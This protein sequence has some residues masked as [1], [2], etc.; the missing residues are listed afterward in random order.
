MKPDRRRYVARGHRFAARVSS[1]RWLT[2]AAFA[3]GAVI[4]FLANK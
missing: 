3:L 4:G 2:A 1:F